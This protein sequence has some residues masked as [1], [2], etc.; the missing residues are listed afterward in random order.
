MTLSVLEGHSFIASLF[1]CHI[2]YPRRVA[3]SLCICRAPNC[4]S[5]AYVRDQGPV[6]LLNWLTVLYCS[7]IFVYSIQFSKHE[8]MYVCTTPL[9]LHV[10][11]TRPFYTYERS[12]YVLP[13]IFF[14]LYEPNFR[15][16]PTH[17][18]EIGVDI[19]RLGASFIGRS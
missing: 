11:I 10:F 6:C 18:R 1:R 4:F 15:D 9:T 5:R 14:Q 13:L 12:S 17:T 3:R 19:C 16:A 8:C 2:T 7:N